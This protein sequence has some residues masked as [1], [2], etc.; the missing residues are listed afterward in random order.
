M[1]RVPSWAWAAMVLAGVLLFNALFTPGFFSIVIRDG[2]FFGSIVDIFNRAAPVGLLALGMTLVIATGGVDLSVGAVMAIGG[3]IAA[4]LISRPGETPFAGGKPQPAMAIPVALFGSL[5]C[6][7]FNGLLVAVIELQ[8]IVATLLLMVAGRGVAQLLA[9]GQ[10][11]TF[12]DSGFAALARGA[13]LGIPNPVWILLIGF[14]LFSVLARKTA[15]GLFVEATGSNPVAA[16]YVGIDARA[17]RFAVYALSGLCAGMAGLITTADIQA[18]DA[19]N[20]G[21]YLE[22]DAIL[23]VSVG[24]TALA[25]GRFSLV[26]SMIGALLM[27]AL[28]TTILTRGVSPEITLVLKAAVVVGVCLLQ[29]PAFRE[30]LAKRI[31]RAP[32]Q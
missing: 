15:M 13:T 10:I 23:A 28:T 32:A 26:G 4:G 22:L 16:Q 25:G 3:T 18:A 6:G 24:G 21:L 29:A 2:R 17:I 11:L 19:N 8:P 7:M 1:R 30:I 12:H 31:R 14:V 20:A 5:L 9:N 27:Q